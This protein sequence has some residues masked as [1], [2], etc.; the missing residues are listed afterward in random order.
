MNNP[1]VL[2]IVTDRRTLQ[3]YM[4]QDVQDFS[5]VF[6]NNQVMGFIVMD[7]HGARHHYTKEHYDYELYQEQI[8]ASNSFDFNQI[9]KD[10]SEYIERLLKNDSPRVVTPREREFL[11]DK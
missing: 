11:E 1:K 7:R 8:M 4:Y 9:K 6:A 5:L 3:E 2:V 10:Y